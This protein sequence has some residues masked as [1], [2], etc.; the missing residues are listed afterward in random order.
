MYPL[1]DTG[2]IALI[3]KQNEIDNIL[4]ASKGTYLMK[5]DGKNTIRKVVLNEEK[6]L[7][8]IS[9]YECLL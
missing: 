4:T 5:L 1:L 2:D 3:Y 7:L 9:C 8:Y 6:K